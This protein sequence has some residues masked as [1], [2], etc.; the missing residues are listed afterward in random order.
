M[1][2]PGS[3]ESEGWKETQARIAHTLDKLRTDRNQ[4]LNLTRDVADHVQE[5]VECGATREQIVDALGTSEHASPEDP[6]DMATERED[7]S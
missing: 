1:P 2:P 7:Q 4:Q 5:A 3:F 6:G